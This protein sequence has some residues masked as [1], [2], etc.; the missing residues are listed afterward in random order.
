MKLLFKQ[1][2]FSWFDSYDIFDENG[3]IMFIVK[4]KM[5]WGHCLEI[6]DAHN[7]HIGTVK[8][9]IF[10]FMPRFALYTGGQYIGDIKKKFTWFK[11]VFLLDCNGWQ[12][13]GDIL[14][15]EYQVV[16]PAG[17]MVM[18]ASKQLFNWTD[19]YVIDVVSPE[20]ALLSLMIVLAIDA[21]KCSR[22]NN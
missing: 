18:S 7:N 4:G 14:E 6:Y 15:W 3:N 20:N 9:E 13:N 10:T 22:N 8:E 5:A 17:N 21:A 19:T 1:K 16:D 2:F 12:V 11:P